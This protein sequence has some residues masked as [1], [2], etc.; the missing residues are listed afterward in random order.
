MILADANNQFIA[1]KFKKYIANMKIIVKNI[2]VKAHHSIELVERYHGL[3]HQIYS[4]ITIKLPD[5]K[6]DLTLQISFEVLNNL[7]RPY[8]LV[9]KVWAFDTY[10][11]RSDIDVSL[12]SIS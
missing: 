8:S 10:F 2:L 3:F 7:I 9:S 5:I 6:S 11:C 4:I 1:R 12:P